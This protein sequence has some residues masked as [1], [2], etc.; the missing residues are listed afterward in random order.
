MSLSPFIIVIAAPSGAGKSS[1][2]RALSTQQCLTYSISCTTRIPREHEVHGRDYY[3]VSEKEFYDLEKQGAFVETTKIHQHYYGTPWKNFIEKN[4]TADNTW[5]V[6]D[7]DIPG[8]LAL[9]SRAPALVSIFL[10][11]PS[12]KD[13]EKRI[14]ERQ[15]H[16]APEE[17]EIRLNKA[18]EEIEQW[19]LFDYTIVNDNFDKALEELN[20][21]LSCETLKSVRRKKY[22]AAFVENLKKS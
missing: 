2:I 9:K 21:I 19:S 11:P 22:L 3:F 8:F 1:L 5:M 4:N 13:L 12:F 7:I 10:L 18:Q 6:L 16:I 20:F 14:L 15:P 17:L